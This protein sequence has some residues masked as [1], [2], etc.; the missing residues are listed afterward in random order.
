MMRTSIG[1]EKV[2]EYKRFSHRESRLLWL[3]RA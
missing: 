2:L 1:L 3:E